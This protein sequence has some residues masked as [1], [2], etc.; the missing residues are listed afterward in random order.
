MRTKDFKNT[1]GITLISLVVS[2]VVLLILAGVS[3]VTLTG[4]NGIINRTTEAKRNS[5]IAEAEEEARLIYADYLIGNKAHATALADL[6]TIYNYDKRNFTMKEDTQGTETINGIKTNLNP[7]LTSTEPE[8]DTFTFAS[9]DT[10]TKTITIS[11]DSISSNGKKYYAVVEGK[12]YEMK[13]ENGTV[14]ISRTPTAGGSNSGATLT[15]LTATASPTG[16]VDVNVNGNNVEIS[17]NSNATSGTA[18]ITIIGTIN[19][20][21][22]TQYAKV[23]IKGYALANSS[24][25]GYYINKGTVQ[26]PEY[27]II[28]VDLLGQTTYTGGAL[29]E[30]ES[31]VTVP[32]TA[33]KSFKSY[34][35]TDTQYTDSHFGTNF[36]IEVAKNNQGTDDR[37]IAMA[38][39]D[40]DT[41]SHTWWR[42]LYNNPSIL[43]TSL[44]IDSGK[45]NSETVK[46]LWNNGGASVQNTRDGYTD[47][48]DF[49]TLDSN[50]KSEWF[51][52]SYNEWKAFGAMNWIDNESTPVTRSI[53]GGTNGSGGNY[54]NT[55]GLSDFYW[56]SSQLSSD[57][58]EVGFAR[59]GF[60]DMSMVGEWYDFNVRMSTTF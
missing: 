48:W 31:S 49:V 18:I 6:E 28:Y 40:V 43:G 38:L 19:G 9:D 54:S 27:A 47:I 41:S 24:Y 51:I 4:D 26:N 15:S 42:W 33:G 7:D 22:Y 55:F 29:Q 34:V 16:V 45:T 32:S 36:I 13:I 52:P 39:N 21:D 46:V 12:D 44:A 30:S 56:S 53:I 20:R 57:G 25:V 1:K 59:F 17:R 5:K 50:N 60:S 58:K 10:T 3:I 35:V 37:F 11:K 14:N 23:S 2:I 8:T